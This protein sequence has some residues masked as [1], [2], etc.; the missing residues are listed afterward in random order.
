M[1]TDPNRIP[2]DTF[3]LYL[4]G[5]AFNCDAL[6]KTTC[7]AALNQTMKPAVNPDISKPANDS[8]WWGLQADLVKVVASIDLASKKATLPSFAMMKSK[9]DLAG[10]ATFPIHLHP[11]GNC[12]N[13]IPSRAHRAASMFSN[14]RPDALALAPL[15]DAR[16]LGIQTPFD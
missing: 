2:S 6:K 5:N 4:G 1:S 14:N 12:S 11:L 15:K 16:E 9:G 3:R 7:P 8:I 10:T 13:L